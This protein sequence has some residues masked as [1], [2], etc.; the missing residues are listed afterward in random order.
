MN[1]APKLITYINKIV[2][3]QGYIHA[4]YTSGLNI[5]QSYISS[6]RYY[7]RIINASKTIKYQFSFPLTN[8]TIKE[9]IEFYNQLLDQPDLY[10]ITVLADKYQFIDLNIDYIESS[11]QLYHNFYQKYQLYRKFV[12]INEFQ[13]YFLPHQ[14]VNST[15]ILCNNPNDPKQVTD[16]LSFYMVPSLCLESINNDKQQVFVPQQPEQQEE[17]DQLQK[18]EQEY[19]YIAYSYCVIATTISTSELLHQGIV[20]AKSLGC[21]VYNTL[22]IMN[23]NEQVLDQCYFTAGTGVL[24]YYLYNYKLKQNIPANQIAIQLF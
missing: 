19:I 10:D 18:K 3:K 4:I 23:I 2:Q 13:H 17:V 8:C 5:Y 11:Y 21:D 6:S 14:N 20:K 7:H 9:T 24:K 22:N 15:I 12:D 16:L 1:L